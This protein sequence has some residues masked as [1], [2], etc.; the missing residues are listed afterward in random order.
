MTNIF[1]LGLFFHILG[2]TLLAGGSLG[3]LLLERQLYRYFLTSPDKALAL[4]PLMGRYPVVIQYGAILMLLSGITLLSALHWAVVSQAWFIIKM[5]LYVALILNGTLV[6]RPTGLQLKELMTH[7]AT[8][9]TKNRFH[10][11]KR[12]MTIFHITE[13]SMLVAI[14]VLAI[15]R[16]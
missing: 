8:N 6:A 3:G 5:F 10:S 16:F 12:K 4:A 11:L 15:Y 2:I 13:F 7:P 9:E 14:Y 1:S